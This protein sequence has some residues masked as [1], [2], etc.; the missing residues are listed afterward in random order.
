VRELAQGKLVEI[1]GKLADLTRIRDALSA[2]SCTCSG[3][4]PVGECPIL[5][6]LEA[7]GGKAEAPP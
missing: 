4:G 2:V 7:C 3:E 5:D 6:A 1:E